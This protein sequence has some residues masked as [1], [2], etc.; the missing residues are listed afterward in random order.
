MSVEDWGEFT[1]FEH[2]I[3]WAPGIEVAIVGAPMPMRIQIKSSPVKTETT[4]GTADVETVLVELAT[5]D[6]DR[7]RELG[8]FLNA[9]ADWIDAG[10]QHWAE[11]ERLSDGNS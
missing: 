7:L 3:W 6:P 4:D 10:L 5:H 2:T 9:A 11:A 8:V 1:S